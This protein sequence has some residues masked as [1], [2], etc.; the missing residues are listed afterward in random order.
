MSRFARSL[1][2]LSTA[3]LLTA[4]ASAGDR[5]PSLAIRDAERVQGTF[6]VSPAAAPTEAP[7][8][9]GTLDRVAQ[10]GAEARSAHA[11]FMAAAPGA[12]QA[13]GAARDAAVTENRWAVAQIALADLDSARSEAAIALGDLDLLYAD[14][15]L[16]FTEREQ[17]GATRR[18]VLA[19]LSEADRIL[20]EL[21]RAAP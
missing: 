3:T 1:L 19:L 10:L 15:T 14:A 4:C 13:V 9:P 2:L 17:I 21:R 18:E 8:P 11:K 6:A 20:A 16:A 5:Y 7:A 12:R